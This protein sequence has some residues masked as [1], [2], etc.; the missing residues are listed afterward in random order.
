VTEIKLKFCGAAK[1]VTGS[2]YLLQT[3]QSTF[4]VDCGL[5][6]GPKSV[7]ALNYE[8]FPFRSEKI[9]FV[10]QTHAHIDHSGLL[11][12]LTSTGFKGHIFATEGTKDLLT[13]M[14]PDS[15]YIQEMEVEHLNRR[16]QRR[17]KAEVSPIYTRKDAEACL[18]HI[19][20]VEY[21]DWVDVGPDV[22]ARFWNAG[23]ILGSASIEVE[24]DQEG[25]KPLRL[26]F[27]GDIGPDNKLFHPDPDAPADFDYVISESTYGDRERPDTSVASRRAALRV[28][29]GKALADDGMLLIP[30][31]AVERTQELI[32]DILAL[33]ASG[34]IPSVPVF[35]DSPLAIRVTKVFQKHAAD[36]ED[37]GARPQLLNN[38]LIHPTETTDESK[39]IA[40]ISGGAIIMA[41]SGM[42]DAGRIRHHL[43]QWLWQKKATVLFVGYQATGSMGRLIS[44]GAKNVTIQGEDI[45]VKAKIRK[46][47]A[48]S[49][50]ADGAELA[51][52]IVERKPIHKALFL[53]HGEED[54]MVALKAKVEALGIDGEKVVM[55]ALDDEITL[56]S[57][58]SLTLISANEQRVKP[59]KPTSPDWDNDLAEMVNAVRD[60]FHSAA[61]EKARAAFVRHMWRALEMDKPT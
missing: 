10:L 39:R 42:C 5:F 48:Y 20:A 23:H 34:E 45:K 51:S 12:K 49:G 25:G 4:L 17:G 33:Q 58:G 19:L 44:E 26:L 46:L 16:N 56:S 7:R 60:G 15:G 32:T 1:H 37:F 28:E 61:D 35:L 6:Q 2:C 30:V 13:F 31:F 14:L 29:V 57:T 41:A 18:S 38:P 43:K 36:L 50:H 47:D 55:P 22:R 11:P 24:I 52:W 53:T 27:S 59:K 9:D 8:P 21:E 54:Q 40:K 3:P